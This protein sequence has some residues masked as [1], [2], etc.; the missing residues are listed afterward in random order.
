[1]AKVISIGKPAVKAKKVPSWKD[2]AAIDRM[3]ELIV[4]DHNQKIRAQKEARKRS[5]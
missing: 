5:E 4:S 1:M 3:K 2:R